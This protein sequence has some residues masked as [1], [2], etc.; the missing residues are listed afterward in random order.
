M[1][2]WT[3]SEPHLLLVGSLESPSERQK[4]MHGTMMWFNEVKD[5][6]MVLSDDGERLTVQ[7]CDFT[8][9]KRPQGR[10]AALPVFFE[11][12]GEGERTASSVSL[13]PQTS[14]G[15]ARPHHS[16]MRRREH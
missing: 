9:G 15:R 2:R 16:G 4:L 6:G 1:L 8:D 5:S 3:G 12:N 10:C 14:H 11:A 13:V 7:G